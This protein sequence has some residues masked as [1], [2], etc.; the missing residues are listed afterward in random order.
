MAGA[1]FILGAG[2]SAHAGAPLMS[3]FLDRAGALYRSGEEAF[4]AAYRRAYELVE[5][6]RA[7]LQMAHSKASLDI[8]DFEEVF[9][10]FEMAALVGRLGELTPEEVERLPTAMRELIE[11]TIE[12]G[13]RLA[14]NDGQRQASAPYLQFAEMLRKVYERDGG[15][16]TVVTFNYDLLLDYAL[17]A[18]STPY[19]YCLEGQPG[20]SLKLLK[21]HGSLNWFRC[22]KCEALGSRSL[23]HLLAR[24]FPAPGSEFWR[25]KFSAKTVQS[26]KC[27]KCQGRELELMLVP[28]TWSKGQFQKALRPV[29]TAC[30]T[31]LSTAETIVVCG[32]S[33]RTSDSFFRHLYAVGSVGPPT[34]KRFWVLCKDP[35][36]E[37]RGRFERVVGPQ[38]RG[39]FRV[40]NVLFE[41]AAAYLR[42]ELR[43]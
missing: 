19:S 30:A 36:P 23:H 2:A 10:A 41:E 29:W 15:W 26:S 14:V 28:P 3:D 22:R 27:P 35:D 18:S 12:D 21:L 17:Y 7:A 13:V 4:G 5:K 33:F 9:D 34:L 37:L 20:P 8:S 11:A 40:E 39:G 38:V 16:P 43:L 6:G 42:R 32:Y 25:L 24:T 1:V 31:A